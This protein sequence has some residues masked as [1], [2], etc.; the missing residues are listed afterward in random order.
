[1]AMLNVEPGEDAC[2]CWKQGIKLYKPTWLERSNSSNGLLKTKEH[3]PELNLPELN[4]H[5]DSR[6]YLLD[7]TS[8]NLANA[9]M[10][11]PLTLSITIKVTLFSANLDH[12]P[13]TTPA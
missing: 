12:R 2:C 7:S 9:C 1:M 13:S 4:I 11:A 6:T 10:D 8:R 3:G 5:L